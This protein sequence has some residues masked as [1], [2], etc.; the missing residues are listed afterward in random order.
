MR[1]A[2]AGPTQ[3]AY[4]EQGA[5]EPVVFLHGAGLSHRMWT[6]Q[7]EHLRAGY[8]CI[9]ADLRG[10]GD[11]TFTG[12]TDAYRCEDH[13]ADV[14]GL[15]DALDIDRAHLVGLSLGG[16]VSLVFGLE[17]P[18]RARS[19]ATIGAPYDAGPDP[20]Q[21]LLL[22]ATSAYM[23]RKTAKH[24]V[25]WA[26]RVG[27]PRLARTPDARA[28]VAAESARHDAAEFRRVW[29]GVLAYRIGDRLPSLR[30]PVLMV[31]G[32]HDRN[33]KQAR[34]G[35]ALIPGARF[36]LVEGAGHITNLDD[37]DAVNAILADWLASQPR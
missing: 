5:G 27:A 26:G 3:V 1:V 18:S 25:A 11:T 12:E 4:D 32:S 7:I 35:A 20:F 14:L 23:Y 24:G 9:A 16:M 15:L 36:E 30:L 19:I 37:P 8:R 6:P 28:F 22:R 34:R 31:A 13:A 21:R 17:H 29:E 10:H 2:A 33:R